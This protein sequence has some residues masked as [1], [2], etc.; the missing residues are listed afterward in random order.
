MNIVQFW[1]VD[2]IVKHKTILPIRLD[3]DEE[4]AQDMLISDGDYNNDLT[5]AFFDEDDVEDATSISSFKIH[6]S[7]S[8]S[9]ESLYELRTSGPKK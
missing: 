9:D 1:V 3:G 4:L 8:I 5:D 7:S 6:R 2:T